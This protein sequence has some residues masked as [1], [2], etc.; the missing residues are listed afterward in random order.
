MFTPEILSRFDLNGPRYTS[1]PTADRLQGG[2]AR[3]QVAE[4]LAGLSGGKC[5]LYVHI[6]FCRSLCYYCACNKIVT[7][8]P[9]AAPRFLALLER[10]ID[11]LGVH[12]GSA[13]L[14]Q[15]ALGGGTPNFLSIDEQRQLIQLID[16]AFVRPPDR[17]QSIELDPRFLTEEYV[18]VLA[19]LG[20]NRVSFGVQDFDHGVQKLIHR[21]QSFAQTADACRWARVA[22]I[23]AISFDFVYGLPLQSRETL[24][25]TLERALSLEP[26][27][28][29]LFNYAHIPERFKAQR[30]IPTEA[31]PPI[32]LRT[33][34]FLYASERLADA[35]YVAIGLDHFAKPSDSLARAAAD[36]SLR[37]NFQGYSTHGGLDLLGIGPSAISDVGGILWQ[38]APQMDV[39]AQRLEAGELPLVRGRIRSPDDRLRADV[40]ERIMCHGEVD[41]AQIEA[42]HGRDP[43]LV[44]A[45]E[46]S[47]LAALAAI[48]VVSTDDR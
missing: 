19:E 3:D 28:I 40:I 11:L 35:G 5:S 32:E 1:Y 8:Q 36:G 31:L 43:R 25:T 47:S 22:G 34:L 15:I 10:E 44:L 39:Y 48:G 4:A 17:E 9:E 37:R 21:H 20:Y 23:H 14:P 29:A 26:D 7:K 38:N 30:R 27:R 18:R 33:E 41:W 46:I 42:R 16:R 2:I 45:S 13:Q 6:P 24:A 12:L